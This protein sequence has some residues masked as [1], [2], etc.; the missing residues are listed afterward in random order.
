MPL[1]GV[2]L[3]E[4]QRFEVSARL[5]GRDQSLDVRELKATSGDSDI[6][7]ELRIHLDAKTRVE[8][9]LA[10]RSIDLT[11]YLAG[12][13]DRPADV[14]VSLSEALPLEIWTVTVTTT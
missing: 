12:R 4:G 7:G 11:P 10:S 9:T 1:L 14:K 8:A 13:G 5:E 3:P 6:E 2:D